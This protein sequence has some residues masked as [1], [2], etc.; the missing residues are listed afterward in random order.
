M[1]K[2]ASKGILLALINKRL[3]VSITMCS[4]TKLISIVIKPADFSSFSDQFVF[5]LTGKENKI[6]KIQ[7]A[8]YFTGLNANIVF[9]LSQIFQLDFRTQFF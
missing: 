2:A 8:I 6:H 9:Y 4:T 7:C 5:Q 3:L 1:K